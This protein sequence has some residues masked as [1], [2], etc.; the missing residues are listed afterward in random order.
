M[1]F[2]H[3]LNSVRV[4]VLIWALCAMLLAQFAAFTVSS[5][6]HQAGEHCCLLC[7]VGPLPFLHGAV[8][9]AITPLF[10]AAWLESQPEFQAPPEPQGV[11]RASRGPPA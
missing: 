7:H 5:Q 6:I 3:R 4:I 9:L 10:P 11:T 8:A 1:A 2:V